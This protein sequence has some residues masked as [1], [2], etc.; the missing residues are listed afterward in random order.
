MFTLLPAKKIYKKT[1]EDLFSGSSL[2]VKHSIPPRCSLWANFYSLRGHF[3]N[4]SLFNV[5]RYCRSPDAANGARKQHRV[6]STKLGRSFK[7]KREY[8]GDTRS[9]AD[10]GSDAFFTPGRDPDPG[11]RKIRIGNG[12]KFMI[13]IWDPGWTSQIIFPRA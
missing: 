7:G 5:Y 3:F 10:P 8:W 2:L 6:I 12:V 9:V 1:S 13:R 11:W 4:W